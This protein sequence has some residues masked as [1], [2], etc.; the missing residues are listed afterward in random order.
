MEYGAYSH[1]GCVRKCNEDSFYVPENA[2]ALPLMMV[3]DGMGGHNAGDVASRLAVDG[4][5]RQIGAGIAALPGPEGIPELIGNALTAAN[6]AIYAQSQAQEILSGMGTTLTLVLFYE[7]I[8]Y[9]AH[10]GDSRGYLIRGNRVI[11]I[12]RDHSLIQELME[13]GSITKE[14]MASHPQKNVITR[15]L[16]AEASIEIDMYKV[17]TKPGDLFLLCS[18]GLIHYIDPVSELSEEIMRMSAAAIAETLGRAA[19]EMGGMDNIT[20]VVARFN[21]NRERGEAFA[22]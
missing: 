22:G 2:H 17:S 19:L 15:A 9:I 20:V 8:A 18:D 7:G 1:I 4:V 11:Q 12:T 5:L 14:E 10:V 6:Q 13:N 3:A 21:G 16:G